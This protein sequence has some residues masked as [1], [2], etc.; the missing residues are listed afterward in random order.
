MYC[1]DMERSFCFLLQAFSIDSF[2]RRVRF[3]NIGVRV[4]VVNTFFIARTSSIARFAV[5]LQKNKQ[6]VII[7]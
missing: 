3:V 5:K 6:N 2:V 7:I 1:Y 4:A